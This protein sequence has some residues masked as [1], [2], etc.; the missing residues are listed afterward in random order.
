MLAIEYSYQ[1]LFGVVFYAAD[2]EVTIDKHFDRLLTSFWRHCEHCESDEKVSYF[3]TKG[4]DLPVWLFWFPPKVRIAAFLWASFQASLQ[5]NL[6]ANV[7]AFEQLF[8]LAFEPAYEFA[9]ELALELAFELA[10]E[11]AFKFAF[12][13]AFEP[14]FGLHPS[15]PLNQ[16]LLRAS[17]QAGF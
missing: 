10:F 14:A 2:L 8:E 16:P 13:P 15:Q 11:P 12:E 17:V 7:P 1:Y 5:S 9:F 4:F 3:S 6:Q